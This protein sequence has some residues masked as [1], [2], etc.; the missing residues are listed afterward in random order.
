V[1]LKC[2]LEYMYIEILV[3]PFLLLRNGLKGFIDHSS[4]LLYDFEHRP[5]AFIILYEKI[6]VVS[7]SMC[8]YI[9]M[10]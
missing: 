4:L 3:H 7:C 1:T 9:G 5:S 8:H 2:S 10:R 6:Q